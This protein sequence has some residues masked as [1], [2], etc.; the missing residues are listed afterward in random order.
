MGKLIDR[1]IELVRTWEDPESPSTIPDLDYH[2]IYPITL[3]EAVKKTEDEH[4]TTLAQELDHIYELFDK[5]QDTI[6]GG[7]VGTLMSWTTEDGVIGSTPL[8]KTINDDPTLR[9]HS[10]IPT[11]R[12]VGYALDLKADAAALNEHVNDP[13]I[14]MTEDDKVALENAVTAETFEEHTSDTDIH[15]TAEEKEVWNAK[16]DAG[17][18]DDHLTNTSNPHSVTAHQIGTYT[19]DEIDSFFETIR[20][21]F[22]SYKNISFDESSNSASLVDYDE[23]LW[24]PNYVLSYG[25]ALPT[26]TDT[27]LTYFA[28]RPVT[29]YSSYETQDCMIYVL[30][31]NASSWIEAGLQTMN[32]GDLVIRYPDTTMC[33][34]I[35]GRFIMLFSGSSSSD[36]SDMMWRPVVDSDGVLGWTRSS[37]TT[38]PDPISI[39]GKDGSTPVKGVDYFDGAPGLGLPAGGTEADLIV[40]ASDADYDTE[41]MSFNDFVNRYFEEG[42]IIEGYISDWNNITNKPEIHDSTGDDATGLMSQAAITSEIESINTRIDNIDEEIGDSSGLGGLKESL[43]NHLQDFNNPHRTSAASIGAVSTTDFNIHTS[44]RQNPHGVTA[45]Q[46]GLGNVN[47]TSDMDKPVSNLAQAKFDE[48]QSNV[49]ELNRIINAGELI[50]NVVWDASSMTLTFIFRDASE[51]MVEIP[52]IDVFKSIEWDA[53]NKQLVIYLPDGSTHAVTINDLITEYTGATS[54][55]IQVKVIDGAIKATLLVHSVTGNELVSDLHLDGNPTTATQS[56]YDNSTHIA[57]TEFVKSLVIDD[58]TSTDTDRPLSANMG[59]QLGD[60]KADIDDV[61]QMID[62]SPLMNTVDNLQSQATDAALSANMGRELNL[63]KATKVHTSASSSTFGRATEDLFGHVRASSLDPLMDGN[64]EVGTDD[65]Y[66]ARADHR[67]P[68]DVTRQPVVLN[69]AIE[70]DGVEY[71]TVENVLNALNVFIN[72]KESSEL[73]ISITITM[74]DGTTA[75]FTTTNGAI[76]GLNNAK[77]DQRLS[78]AIVTDGNE[79]NTV[80]DAIDVLNDNKQNQTIDTITINGSTYTTVEATLNGL[81]THKQNQQLASSITIDGGDYSTVETVLNA[82]NVSLATK[83]SKTLDAPIEI[84]GTLYSTVAD[85]ISALNEY[86]DDN[87]EAIETYDGQL[88]TLLDDLEFSVNENGELLLTY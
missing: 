71:G 53:D 22:F 12:A 41:W 4:A 14:H 85:A 78:S 42:G 39:K 16:A 35:Q 60:R 29:D 77:Q 1:K 20:S 81:N 5:K 18:I 6:T 31:P 17:V 49:D 7:A 38:P 66:Y 47:N 62:D 15:V 27:S 36:G 87:K 68:S 19:R 83:Q 54:E 28:L 51:L 30:L 64:A 88:I 34:W 82:L 23:T 13:Y 10:N 63:T 58:L 56:T 2:V 33:V 44:N 26:P 74:P 40:K 73:P 21:T 24:N 69:N 37:E 8:V 75:T 46:L 84:N 80:E 72:T 50:S 79:A 11:E 59:K 61:V 3:Y 25:D 48:V 32:P 45:A 86:A 57:T 65:G 55:N 76:N 70:V 52:M 9:S 67:H 43:D